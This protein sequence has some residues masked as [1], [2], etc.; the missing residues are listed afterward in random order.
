M[1]NDEQTSPNQPQQRKSGRGRTIYI[2]VDGGN[3]V[4]RAGLKTTLGEID[5]LDLEFVD[6]AAATGKSTSRHP[7][8]MIILDWPNQDR[9]RHEV[10]TRNHDG[11]FAS[12]IALITEDSPAALRAALRAGADDVLQM[13]PAPAQ[14]LH[15][16]LRMSELARLTSGSPDKMI[17]S[18]TSVTGGVGVSYL[19][20]GLALAFHRLF[21]KRT[22]ILELDLQAAPL[23]TMLG[24]EPEHT[25]GELA[26]PTSVIDSIRLES[27][28]C[29]HRV[30]CASTQK[31]WDIWAFLAIMI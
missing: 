15:S 13:P 26:D 3:D 25:I 24:V 30:S 22:V 11:K 6:P 2:S 12:V 19:T 23:A 4:Q 9:W 5:E 21:Q 27:V 18:L 7:I 31:D 8:L 20:A 1:L 14:V 10:R 16:L 17:C 29:K 28:L